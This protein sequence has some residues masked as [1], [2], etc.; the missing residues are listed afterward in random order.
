MNS[1]KVLQRKKKDSFFKSL[2]KYPELWILTALFVA[3]WVIFYLIPMYGIAYGFFDYFPGK[4]LFNSKFI[5]LKHFVDFVKNQDFG[6]IVRNTLVIGGLNMSI[7][8]VAP[9]IL[10]LL[11][12]ELYPGKFKKFT[13]T[14]SYLPYFVSWVVVASLATSMLNSDGVINSIL[15][16][17]G[18]I[19]KP[20]K[21][22]T[23]GKYFWGIITALNIW[24]SVGWNTILYMSAIAGIDQTLY[25]AGAVDG[26]N[27]WG[28]VK[29]ITIPSIMPTIMLLFIL[30]LGNM[31]NLGYEANL[32]LGQSTTRAYWETIDTYTYRYGIQ[33]GR[34]S[35][36]IAVGVLKSVISIVLIFLSNKVVRKMTDYSIL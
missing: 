16:S 29:H 7:G 15:L 10:S 8:F 12:D 14:V 18:A 9:I 21:F 25:E 2:K 5:G 27:R 3:W 23:E 6:N 20:V 24:K 30:G 31:I 13:Q 33:M 19:D 22:L 4:S 1:T 34:Y 36:A 32:L 26:L 17:I 28:M 11:L 35:F